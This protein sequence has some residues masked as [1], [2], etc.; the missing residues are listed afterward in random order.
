MDSDVLQY[1]WP[2]RRSKGWLYLPIYYRV[3]YRVNYCEFVVLLRKV[4]FLLLNVSCCV[5]E[6]CHWATESVL[7]QLY[8]GLVFFFL[9]GILT[10]LFQWTLHN[11]FKIGFL[12]YVNFP[13][14]LIT[15]NY[16]PPATPY[17]YVSEVFLCFIFS[18]FIR[19]RHFGWWARNNCKAFDEA[20]WFFF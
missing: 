18:Y 6:G 10:P 16:L 19:R 20:G 5:S 17:N 9:V 4:W 2:F 11:K 7:S 1:R 14:V 12:K 8:Y 3:R 13:L 15:T